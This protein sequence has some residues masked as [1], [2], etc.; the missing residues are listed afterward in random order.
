M[1]RLAF[2][3]LC[4]V[5]ML[6]MSMAAAGTASAALLWLLCL[7]GS[8]S[9]NTKYEDSSCTKAL[10]TGKWESVAIGSK[11]DTVRLLAFSLL[12]KDAVAGTTVHCPDSGTGTGL[13]EGNKLIIREAKISNPVGEGCTLEGKFLTCKETANLKGIHAVNLPW[14]TE[15]FETEKKVLAQ[16]KANTG[17]AGWA[18]ECGTSTDICEEESG[19]PEFTELVNGVTNKVLL[20]LARFESKGLGDCT[21]GGKASGL[22]GGLIAILLWN[23]SGLSIAP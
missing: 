6:V 13:V 15:M 11:S 20:V 8:I 10:S 18:V 21:V 1:R 14:T 9:S 22:V 3:A 7:E 23:G 5:S 17:K 12:L 4:F 19:K 16:V 2:A